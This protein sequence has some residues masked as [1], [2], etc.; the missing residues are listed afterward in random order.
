MKPE[1]EQTV[2]QMVV[3]FKKIIHYL[4]LEKMSGLTQLKLSVKRIQIP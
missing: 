3:E 1:Y 4:K 2:I